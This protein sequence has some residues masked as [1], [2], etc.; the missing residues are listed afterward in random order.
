MNGSPAPQSLAPGPIPL[1]EVVL[2]QDYRAP[3]V[4]QLRAQLDDA[5]RL[6]PER[7]VVDVTRCRTMDASAIDV[8]LDAHRRLRRLGGTLTLRSPSGRLLRNLTLTRA[9]L[10][11]DL[12]HAVVPA[13]RGAT[14]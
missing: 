7:L 9:D 3:D 1:I 5:V 14:A 12:G 4:D 6:R 13:A 10:V 8:L 2:R 11:L